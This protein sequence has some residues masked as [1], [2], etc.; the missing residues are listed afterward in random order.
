MSTNYIDAKTPKTQNPTEIED[1][2]IKIYFG[3]FFDGS[4][5]SNGIAQNLSYYYRIDSNDDNERH[6][7]ICTIVKSKKEYS[8]KYE[9]QNIA[10]IESD[11]ELAEEC[12]N[13]VSVVLSRINGIL[14][15]FWNIRKNVTI[16]IDVFGVDEGCIP[17]IA[18]CNIA[19]PDSVT[20]D[21]SYIYER[22]I[23]YSIEGGMIGDFRCEGSKVYLN[24]YS[25]IDSSNPVEYQTG[26]QN[27]L[28]YGSVEEN[29]D[30]HHQKGNYSPEG[31]YDG[32]SDTLTLHAYVEH[33]DGYIE[34]DANGNVQFSYGAEIEEDAQHPILDGIQFALDMTSLALPPGLEAIPSLINAGISASRGNWADAGLSLLCIV[35]VVSDAAIAAKL[36]KSGMKVAKTLPK[37]EKAGNVIYASEKFAARGVS[38]V[39]KSQKASNVVDMAKERAIREGKVVD[40]S[41]K[42]RVQ[43]IKKKDGTT[44]KEYIEE[45][46]IDDYTIRKQSVDIKLD[47]SGKIRITNSADEN[48]F[49]SLTHLNKNRVSGSGE[50]VSTKEIDRSAGKKLGE[51][52]S[53]Q[54]NEKDNLLDFKKKESNANSSEKVADGWEKDRQE[55]E[56]EKW[57]KKDTEKPNPFR[58]YNPQTSNAS[59]SGSIQNASEKT[60]DRLPHQTKETK[61][62]SYRDSV[63]SY[64]KY[65][66]NKKAP[67]GYKRSK[68]LD[69]E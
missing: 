38:S 15:G 7:S 64:N 3:L 24:S 43:K 30:A 36:A 8:V 27:S 19:E 13:A 10:E 49:G 33:I 60:I 61:P 57:M 23:V 20:N 44:G 63:D 66:G 35:P 55:L 5:A 18:F 41:K 46:P 65:A 52:P 50:T 28:L 32:G 26:T 16:Y 56:V 45:V 17:A 48:Q 69:K 9:K 21:G 2:P 31:S 22:T 12:A 47:N 53:K 29:Y 14:S 11:E 4:N 37:V 59:N 1:I 39:K 6:Y 68:S 25:F 58:N 54:T 51:K 34:T 67:K 40:I 42:K 62:T